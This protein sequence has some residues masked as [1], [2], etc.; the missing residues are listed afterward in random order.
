MTCLQSMFFVAFGNRKIHFQVVFFSRKVYI[1][2]GVVVMKKCRLYQN[3][4][5]F[6]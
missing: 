1:I 2:Q 6:Q 3:V 5:P 4:N